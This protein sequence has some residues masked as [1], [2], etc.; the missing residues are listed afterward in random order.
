MRILFDHN[1]P[2][3]L[4][5]SFRNWPVE[6]AGERGWQR[7]ANGELLDAAEAEGFDILLTADKGF[8]HQLNLSDRRIGIVI[9][10]RGNWPDVKLNIPK[11]LVSIGDAKSGTCTVVECRVC[12]ETPMKN[13]AS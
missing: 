3:P 11:I 8:Q 9:L 13:N 2:V 12:S 4:R 6:T 10:S 1:V 7:L 5:Y